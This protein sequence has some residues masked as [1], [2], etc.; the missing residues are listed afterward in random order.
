V[1]N[2]KGRVAALPKSIVIKRGELRPGCT[3]LFGIRLAI[4]VEGNLDKN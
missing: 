2:E 1:T 3:L 4:S